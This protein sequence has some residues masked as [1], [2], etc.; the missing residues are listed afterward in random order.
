MII[1]AIDLCVRDPLYPPGNLEKAVALY[2]APDFATGRPGGWY[3]RRTHSHEYLLPE[4]FD[5]FLFPPDGQRSPWRQ[6]PHPAK[7]MAPAGAIVEPTFDAL[8]SRVLP[9]C[10]LVR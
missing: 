9:I 10:A 6:D 4:P 1:A 5:E 7:G 2:F 3:L 8:L